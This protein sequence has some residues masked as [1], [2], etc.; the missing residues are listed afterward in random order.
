[1]PHDMHRTTLTRRNFLASAAAATA[2]ATVGSAATAQDRPPNIVFILIDDLGWA[3]VGCY[4]NRF[5]ETPNID[6][7]ASQGMR[8]TDAYAACPVC[9]PT[10]ASIL[11]G[12]Y[13]ARVG[14]TDFITGH[15]RPYAKMR[16]P[17]NR[18]QYLP[19]EIET[20]A[21]RLKTAGYTTGAYGKWH[22]GGQKHFPQH[23]GFDDF[24]V[25]GGPHFKYHTTPPEEVS[26]DT[27]LA[28]H[29]TDKAESFMESNKDKPF[30]LYLSHYA[31]HIP[32]QAKRDLIAKYE[33]KTPPEE[34]VNHPVY[35]AM[36]EHVDNSVGRVMAKIDEL[37]IADN[38]MVV[39]FSD[40]GGLRKRFDDQGDVV[41]SNAPLRQE[42][43][44]VYEGGIR[45]PLIVR[46]PGHVEAGSTCAEPVTSVDFYPTF[47]ELSGASLPENQVADG[48]SIL[49]LLNGSSSID[50]DAIF[51]HYPHYHHMAPA[52]AVR[53]GMWK[54]IENYES[55][56][57][58]LY[59]LEADIG[60]SANLADREPD[61]AKAM[62]KRLALWRTS[63]NAVMPAPNPD[64]DPAREGEWGR[65]P[66]RG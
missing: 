37:G 61:R 17:K 33:K 31:V 12:Q 51:W 2:V 29:L 47:C 13:P 44:T 8:F 1:M 39:F 64:Y 52:G 54:L 35:A 10:R 58:E 18:T 21:E 6:R 62:Q 42:K 38:T 60:E 4:G 50:R 48:M 56:G 23:Q 66:D 59:D 49:P 22:L 65:H 16:V 55:G 24:M 40:N 7:L 26:D 28:D 36:V 3:D 25:H 57:L 5:N 46:W 20:I 19:L 63:V 45:E 41:T 34:G 32:L 53:M 14:I 27:Y 11:S 43:G 30:F 15:W 9:S